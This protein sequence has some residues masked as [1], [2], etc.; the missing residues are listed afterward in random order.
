MSSNFLTRKEKEEFRSLKKQDGVV[1]YSQRLAFS[2]FGVLGH[3]I[4][5]RKNGK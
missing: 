3:K 1:W 2:A 4:I 5:K